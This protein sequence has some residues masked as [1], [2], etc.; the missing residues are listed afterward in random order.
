MRLFTMFCN[1]PFDCNDCFILNFALSPPSTNE[2]RKRHTRIALWPHAESARVPSFSPCLEAT[3]SYFVGQCSGKQMMMDLYLIYITISD[4]HESR[5]SAAGD[6]TRGPRYPIGPYVF[7]A[8]A[9]LFFCHF[10]FGHDQYMFCLLSLHVW[11]DCEEC[12]G[13]PKRPQGMVIRW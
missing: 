4:P 2:S 11:V 13:D 12:P 6:E 10:M 3:Q 5:E 1:R 9:L 8:G 7:E